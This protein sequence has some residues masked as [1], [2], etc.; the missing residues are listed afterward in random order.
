[1]DLPACHSR[2]PLPGESAVFYCAHPR[3][4]IE[5]GR[6]TAQICG[7]CDRWKEPAPEV[8]RPFPPP[9]PRD[10]CVHLG[11]EVGLRD[12]EGCRGTVKV[13]VFACSHPAHRETT[14]ANCTTCGDHEERNHRGTEGTEKT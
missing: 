9:R 1:M 11:Q 13:R 7:M 12:C 2:R 14:L 3:V 4:F 6:V 8:F 10:P 5:G